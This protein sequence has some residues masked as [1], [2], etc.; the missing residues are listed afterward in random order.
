MRLILKEWALKKMATQ[1]QTFKK[2][3]YKDYVKEKIPEFTGPPEKQR[4]H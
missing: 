4:G 1:F 2:I 3:L